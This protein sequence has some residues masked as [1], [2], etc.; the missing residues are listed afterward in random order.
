MIAIPFRP[1][2]KDIS[3]KNKNFSAKNYFPTLLIVF[4]ALLFGACKDRIFEIY[5]ASVP[6]YMTYEELRKSVKNLEPQDLKKPGKIYFKDNYIFINEHFKG[7]HIVDNNDP[8]HPVIKAF[9][10]IPGNVDIAIKENTLFADSYID[11]VAIDINNMNDI[12]ES[13]RI[14]DVFPYAA[15]PKDVDFSEEWA[16]PTKG[17]VISWEVKEVERELNKPNPN[18]YPYVYFYAKYNGLM[19]LSS[20]TS[21]GGT[22]SGSAIGAGGSMARFAIKNNALY[23]LS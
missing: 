15:P 8:A 16:D 5:K 22:G 2:K 7:I 11:L 14:K 17:V 20:A 3:N 9:I 21:G 4:T 18:P 13:Y 12:K 6:V 10:N 23:V 1:I 19:D